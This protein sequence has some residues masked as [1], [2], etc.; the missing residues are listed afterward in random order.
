MN[1]Q[2]NIWHLCM[3]IYAGCLY[4]ALYSS[5]GTIPKPMTEPY[6]IIDLLWIAS[7]FVVIG[8]ICYMA[9]YKSRKQ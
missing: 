7:V 5:F 3:A 9:G 4:A 1:K 2:F 6:T 8:F